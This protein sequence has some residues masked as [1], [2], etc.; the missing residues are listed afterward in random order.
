[1]ITH[2]PAVVVPQY[3]LTWSDTVP[4]RGMEQAIQIPKTRI[5]HNVVAVA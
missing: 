3:R 4:P 5:K 2:I 1:M